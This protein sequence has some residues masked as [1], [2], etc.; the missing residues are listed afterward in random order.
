MNIHQCFAA[1]AGGALALN[2]WFSMQA[3]TRVEDVLERANKPMAHPVPAREPE[4]PSFRGERPRHERHRLP[5]ADGPGCSL[6]VDTVL[7][8]DKP[9]PQALAFGIGLL[10]LA[11]A[12]RAEA[13]TGH[14]QPAP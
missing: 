7:K 8:V 2:E 9:N 10:H 4:P 13:D 1:A 5:Q 14:E 11:R 6:I 3:G 12:G